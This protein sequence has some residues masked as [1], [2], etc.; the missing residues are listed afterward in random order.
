MTI[1]LSPPAPASRKQSHRHLA[2]GHLAIQHNRL[3]KKARRVDRQQNRLIKPAKT[4]PAVLIG[5]GRGRRGAGGRGDFIG[6]RAHRT[7]VLVHHH[8]VDVELG[9]LLERRVERTAP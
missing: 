2:A 5:L 9:N 4:N 1:R 3:G 7:A 6:R 8:D